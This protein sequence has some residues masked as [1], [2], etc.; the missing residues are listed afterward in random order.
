MNSIYPNL[1]KML[2]ERNI[3][4]S[5]L[6]ELLGESKCG[7]E[8]KLCGELPWLLSDAVRICCILNT[9]DVNFLFCTE[10]NNS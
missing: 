3:T 7:V 10:N 6:A 8:L 1:C 9:S 5:N 2:K 4:I